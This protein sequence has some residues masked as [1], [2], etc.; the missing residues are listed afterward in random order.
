MCGRGGSGKR[1]GGG[2][3]RWEGRGK[4]R[5]RGEMVLPDETE[6]IIDLTIWM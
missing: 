4:G 1:R 2:R 6:S 5:A 3:M